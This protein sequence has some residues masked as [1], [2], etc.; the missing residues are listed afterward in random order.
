M[1][2]LV[3]PLV[4]VSSAY[5]RTDTMPGWLQW[6]ADHQ[7]ITPMVDAVRSLTLGER[8]AEVLGHSSG[9]YLVPALAWC[10]AL[11]AVFAPVAIAR[12]RRG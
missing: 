4:F 2:L 10:V 8:S 9:H 11:V 12:Y 1:S 6:I 7:P 5:V 3:S